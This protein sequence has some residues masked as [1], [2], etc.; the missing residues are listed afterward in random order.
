MRAGKCVASIHSGAESAIRTRRNKKTSSSGLKWSA[1]ATSP[2]GSIRLNAST[3]DLGRDPRSFIS[4]LKERSCREILFQL[5]P[6]N[7]CALSALAERQPAAAQGF[8]RLSGRHPAYTQL[9]GNFLLR[10][11]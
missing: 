2:S 3:F 8:Q 9:A 10:R 5:H 11:D 6:R 1:S 7:K 4:S